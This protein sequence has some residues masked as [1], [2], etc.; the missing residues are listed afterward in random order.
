MKIRVDETINFESFALLA[1]RADDQTLIGGTGAEGILKL[2]G[3]SGN[4]NPTSPAIQF[5]V[6]NNGATI[7]GTILNN[8]N[9]G[10]GTTTP[11]TR[12]HIKVGADQNVKFS[13]FVNCTNGTSL[14]A[15]N[16]ISANKNDFEIIALNIIFTPT[17]CI[18]IGTASPNANA[19]LDVTSTTKAFMPPRM[20][21]TER[22][23]IPSPTEGMVIYNITTHVLDHYN[24][25]AWGAV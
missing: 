9:F 14:T 17:N 2:Q 18:G 7:A 22:D 15:S 20:T 8:G 6:G 19:I 16:D 1:G 21:T 12:L 25:S 23:A 10:F 5:L 11:E 3:T 4:G 24:G 13:S